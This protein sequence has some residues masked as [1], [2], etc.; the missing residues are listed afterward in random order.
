MT[1]TGKIEV[2]RQKDFAVKFYPPQTPYGLTW[3]QTQACR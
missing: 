2:I 3:G 1:L